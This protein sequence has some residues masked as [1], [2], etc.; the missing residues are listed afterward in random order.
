MSVEVPNFIL[1]PSLTTKLDLAKIIR[2]VEAIGQEL[3]SQ[4]IRGQ[5]QDGYKIPPMS[6]GLSDFL[7]INKIDFMNDQARMILSEQ[8]RA[9]KDKVPI[10]HFTFASAADPQSLQQLVAWIRKELHPWT[11]IEV[12]VQPALIGGAYIRTPNHVH[13]FSMRSLFKNNSDVL[14]KDLEELT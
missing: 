6:S 3:E 12:G 7:S 5:S 4:K 13:D 2:E 1:P 9:L 14:V 11:L 10:I 8:L